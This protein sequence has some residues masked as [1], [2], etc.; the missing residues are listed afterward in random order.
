MTIKDMMK[1]NI[2]SLL[3][4][5]ILSAV[6]VSPAFAATDREME[7]ARAIAAKAYLRYVNNGSGY[8]DEVQAKSIAELEKHLK[9]KEKENIKAFLAV[10]APADYAGWDREKLVEYW[11]S[12]LNSPSLNSEGKAARGRVRKQIGAMNVTVTKAAEPAKNEETKPAE[13]VPTPSEA[14]AEANMAAPAAGD[15]PADANAEQDILADQKAIAED[16]A[17]TQSLEK[18]SNHTWLY[19]IILCL[20]VG[21][22]IWLV[23][24]AAKLMKKQAPLSDN[25]ANAIRE[26][27]RKTINALKEN[28]ADATRENERLTT[29]VKTLRADNDRMAAE[30]DELR[31][32]LSTAAAAKPT[33]AP[34]QP[35]HKPEILKVIYLGRANSRGLFVRADR[36]FSPGNTI[37]RLDTEDGMVGTYHVVDNPAVIGIALEHPV[38]MLGGGCTAVDIQDTAGAA[39]IVT[40]SSGTAI[41]ENGCW[42]VLRKAR[43]HYE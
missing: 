8:L 5:A 28:L 10:K 29:E 9:A 43:I 15:V 39:Q 3:M 40:E 21:M 6:S 27:A 19:V 33:E 23:A 31:K 32:K 16:A 4:L 41:F 17:P 20:L 22:V 11:V 13:A 24:Y 14:V 37:Y 34:Q 42:K 30:L 25:D 1:N 36:K 38:E 35:A 2:L 7:E 12:V 18:E 26:G